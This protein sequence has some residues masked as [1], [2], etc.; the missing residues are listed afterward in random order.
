MPRKKKEYSIHIPDLKKQPGF[1]TIYVKKD[2]EIKLV[3]TNLNTESFFD[4][5]FTNLIKNITVD[6]TKEQVLD[7]YTTI[8]E[9]KGIY[10]TYT[11]SWGHVWKNQM[12]SKKKF[13]EYLNKFI[14]DDFNKK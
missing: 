11:D 13:E 4:I 5:Y 8:W 14:K 7:K 12:P 10:V 9:N 3:A 6:T 2:S 1:F